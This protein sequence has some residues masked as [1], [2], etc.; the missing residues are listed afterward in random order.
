M[1]RKG[2]RVTRK[3]V[4]R[5]GRKMRVIVPSMGIDSMIKSGVELAAKH[6]PLA[7]KDI[8]PKLL[9]G[10]AEKKNKGED[11]IHNNGKRYLKRNEGMKNSGAAQVK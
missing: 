3:R 1:A 6:L 2:K 11:F 5:G 10:S 4:K 9:K 7:K 8:L